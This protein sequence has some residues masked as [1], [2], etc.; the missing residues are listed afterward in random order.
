MILICLADGKIQPYFWVKYCMTTPSRW[1]AHTV[2][3]TAIHGNGGRKCSARRAGN[4]NF[5][6]RSFL[7]VGCQKLRGVKYQISRRRSRPRLRGP[8]WRP[9]RWGIFVKYHIKIFFNIRQGIEEEFL[10]HCFV[11]FP[12]LP[13]PL[14]WTTLEILFISLRFWTVRLWGTPKS[15]T[16]SPDYQH[17]LVCQEI[18]NDFN[19]KIWK[20][21]THW[22]AT[23][24]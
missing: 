19:A 21:M 12:L 10:T 1:N 8:N 6:V 23:C 7:R 17:I 3:N 24:K 16:Q 5:Y 11:M 9:E 13:Y 22:L 4:A 14:I 20:I 18:T 15:S 2:V